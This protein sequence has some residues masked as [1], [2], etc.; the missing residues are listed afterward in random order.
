MACLKGVISITNDLVKTEIIKEISMNRL[1]IAALSLLLLVFL[2]GC[3]T[4]PKKRDRDNALTDKPGWIL[5]TPIKRGFIY[6]VGSAEV[7][8]GNEAAALSRAKDFARVELVKQIEVEV[9]GSV[10]QEMLEVTRNNKSEF[11]QQLRQTVSSKV[12]EFKL[13]H[14]EQV[15]SYKE[16]GSRQVA[17][18]IRLDVKEEVRSL[19]GQISSLDQ[20]LLELETK[21]AEMQGSGLTRL[22]IGTSALV[23]ADQRAGLQARLNQLRST[24]DPL[25]TTSIKMLLENIYQITSQIKVSLRTNG[26][27]EQALQTALIAQLTK[28]GLKISASGESDIEIVYALRTTDVKRGETYFVITEGDIWVKDK[29]GEIITAV[30]EKAKGAS[31]DPRLAKSRSIEKLSSGLGIALINALL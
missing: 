13:S 22:R 25:L 2:A 12:P 16:E 30:Q 28:K 31:V 20:Q 21:L 29:T 6:G 19:Q 15:D 24:H 3:Q 7:F 26:R 9:Q 4:A 17:V 10:E 27:E 1:Y 14:V 18:L 23:L 5:N 8:G 11:T